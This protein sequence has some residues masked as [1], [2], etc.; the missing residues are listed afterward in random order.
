MIPVVIYTELKEGKIYNWLTLPALA[1]GLLLAL[2]VG[3]PTTMG[4]EFPPGN[5]TFM[6]CLWAALLAGG[7]FFVPYLISGLSRGRP[8]IGG[9]DVKLAA[10]IGALMGVSFC[11]KVIYYSVLTGGAIGLG[12]IAWK[13]VSS[14]FRKQ[15]QEEE[16]AQTEAVSLLTLR[17]PFGTAIC[18]G[19][20]IAFM[21]Q[22]L[23]DRQL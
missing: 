8:V 6:H 20:M 22:F 15:E 9:G 2:L 7:I 3:L 23:M 19:V 16:K 13:A 11:L 18:M 10:A 5:T 1:L 12:I 17:I 14:R 21:Q 4:Q